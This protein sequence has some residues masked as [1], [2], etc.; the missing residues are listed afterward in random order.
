MTATAPTLTRSEWLALRATGLGSSDAAAACGES[1][2]SP[3]EL[4]LR[5]WGVMP[6]PDLS[7]IEAVEW[8]QLLQPIIVRKTARRSGLR[9]L[10]T[11]SSKEHAFIEREIQASGETEVIGWLESREAVLRSVAHPWMTATI[12]GIGIDDNAGLID[13]EAKNVG[14]Y[15]SRD[16]NIEDGQAPAK[17]DVQLAHQLAVAPAFQAGLLAGLIG[18]NSLRVLRRE[19]FDLELTIEAIITIEA[20]VW[21]CV[22]TGELP[23]YDGSESS[24]SYLRALR[25]LHPNDNG[26]SIMLPEGAAYW[27][28]ELRSLQAE[29]RP[30]EKRIKEIRR[31]I[32]VAMGGNTFGVLPGG[33]GMYSNRHQT[34]KAYQVEEATFPVLRFERSSK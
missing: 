7:D 21:R 15:H 13:I 27:H 20:E 29:H 5:K 9:I 4:V 19:R 3:A 24:E 28:E 26:Q 30:R 1:N 16:W 6:D 12:D 8:G 25:V 31:M 23:S 14:G 10:G 33:S 32:E 22:Q 11:E 18:G 34:R 17:F 2:V